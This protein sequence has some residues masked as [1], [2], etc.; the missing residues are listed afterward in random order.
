MKSPKKLNSMGLYRNYSKNEIQ[1][2]EIVLF[3]HRDRTADI[4]SKCV[5]RKLNSKTFFTL[6]V[7]LMFE[8]VNITV[9]HVFSYFMLLKKL[10]VKGK[11][12]VNYTY[13]YSILCIL[14]LN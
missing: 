8:N 3:I 7:I 12:T 5:Q 4:G 2:K 10:K 11:L 14:V 1:Q 6:A 9:S 13:V